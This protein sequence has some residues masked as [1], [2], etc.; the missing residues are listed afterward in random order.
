MEGSGERGLP[1]SA[2]S[3]PNHDPMKNASRALNFFPSLTSLDRT[4]EK[5][6]VEVLKVCPV[7]NK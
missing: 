5:A 7:L 3:S 6:P 1:S 2:L 4:G